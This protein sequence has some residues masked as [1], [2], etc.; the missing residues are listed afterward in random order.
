MPYSAQ[1]CSITKA[2]LEDVYRTLKHTCPLFQFNGWPWLVTANWAFA[3]KSGQVC[4]LLR[5]FTGVSG[6]S[7][8]TGWRDTSHP[9]WFQAPCGD[10][11]PVLSSPRRIHKN[12]SW[13]HFSWSASKMV[14]G[15]LSMTLRMLRVSPSWCMYLTHNKNSLGVWEMLVW[16]SPSPLHN[17]LL[18]GLLVGIHKKPYEGQRGGASIPESRRWGQIIFSTETHLSIPRFKFTAYMY[19]P[20]S[21]Y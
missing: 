13:V 4:G 20:M 11:A 16:T 17:A 9:S 12:D 2:E 5:H 14:R 7:K 15:P 10:P 8:C 3:S 1:S 21:M 19:I 18:V 6:R